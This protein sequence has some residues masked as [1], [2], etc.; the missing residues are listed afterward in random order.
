M[1]ILISILAWL[2]SGFALYFTWLS[3]SGSLTTLP[4]LPEALHGLVLV[5]GIVMTY[6]WLALLI[7]NIAWIRGHKLGKFWPVSGPI[8]GLLLILKSAALAQG[9]LLFVASAS[10]LA[11]YLVYY[12]LLKDHPTP[13][14][15]LRVK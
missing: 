10:V 3:L 9:L 11:L 12:H 6:A 2:F 5:E 4:V 14:I 8:V 1:K 15:A 7:M 13:T